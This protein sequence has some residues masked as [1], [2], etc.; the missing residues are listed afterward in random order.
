[1]AQGIPPS[2]PQ[3]PDVV[4]RGSRQAAD[5]DVSESRGEQV[6]VDEDGVGNEVSESLGERLCH[7]AAKIARVLSGRNSLSD[8]LPRG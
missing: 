5:R 8:D 2:M 1:M 4:I 3:I 7:V 6:G